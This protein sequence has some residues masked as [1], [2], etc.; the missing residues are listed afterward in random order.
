MAIRMYFWRRNSLTF[1]GFPDFEEG[2]RLGE[3][4]EKIARALSTTARNPV[5]NPLEVLVRFDGYPDQFALWWDGFSCELGCSEACG[6]NMDDI[7]RQLVAAGEFA[8]DESI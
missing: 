5:G 8:R 3:L 2:S 7:S 1:L 4:I 6:I